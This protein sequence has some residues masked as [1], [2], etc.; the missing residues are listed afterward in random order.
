M[1]RLSATKLDKLNL[2][3]KQN[4]TDV[5]EEDKSFPNGN[6]AT[7][8]YFHV[9]NV[10]KEFK[11]FGDVV[12]KENDEFDL[13]LTGMGYAKLAEV[14]NGDYFQFHCYK[15]DGKYTYKF[16]LKEKGFKDELDSAEFDAKMET[17]SKDD[18]SIQPPRE[19]LSY[20]QR[21]AK[22]WDD[23]NWRNRKQIAWG[24]AM[25]KA[26]D[27]LGNV[28]DPVKYIE[29]TPDEFM[30]RAVAIAKSIYPSLLKDEE[31]LETI[32]NK[33]VKN[34]DDDALPF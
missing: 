25:N 30:E 26:I 6:T 23:I 5:R 34:E 27:L 2:V 9:K 4:A 19:E 15:E 7:Y 16:E 8:F 10:G 22:K 1:L 33:S 28:N 21:E 29:E 13:E 24:Q 12:I 32:Y 31:E 3:A 17:I 11:P 14:R 18:G 20:E